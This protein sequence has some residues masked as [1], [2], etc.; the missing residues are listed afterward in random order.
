MGEPKEG[1]SG[2]WRPENRPTQGVKTLTLGRQRWREPEAR[3]GRETSSGR[4]RGSRCRGCGWG[5]EPRSG[6]GSG[7]AP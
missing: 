3:P 7:N 6:P 1:R 5:G 4:A 2:Q